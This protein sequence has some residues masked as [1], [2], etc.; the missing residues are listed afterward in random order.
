M[1]RRLRVPAA[2]ALLTFALLLFCKS[3]ARAQD[4]VGGAGRTDLSGGAGSSGG[5]RSSTPR[6]PKARAASTVRTVTVTKVVKFTAT[7]GT[8]A[9]AAA[10]EAA[11][12]IE[13]VRG[14]EGKEGTVPKGE[15]VFIFNDLKPG[16]YRVAAELDGYQ[17]AEEEVT[18][19]ANKNLS[20]T[21]DL[22]PI[23]YSVT[24]AANVPAGEVRY[25]PV[26]AV[27]DASGEV[28]YNVAGETRVTP[29][30]GGRA[31]LPN[32][33]PGTYGVDVRSADVGYQTLLATFTL[34]GQTTYSVTL[35]KNLSTKTFSAAWASLDAWE[36]PA[37]W[38]VG[39][40]KLSVSGRGIALPKDESA[41]HY[42]DF[43]LFS[44][45]KML[46]GVAV[47]YVV[48]AQDAQNYYLIQITGAKADEPY[49]LRG[50]VV[51]NG[52]A[53]RFGSTI[54]VDAFTS[55]LKANQFFSVSMEATG[56][57]FKVSI[58]DSETG[59]VL[60]LGTLEDPNRNFP[61][62]AAGVAV[63]DNEQNEV[64]RFVVCTSESPDCP[65]G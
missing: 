49:V 32:L 63:R 19:T 17:P 14:G 8:L 59:D 48:R 5:T 34:P 24:I 64:E 10:S 58:T 41:R 23:T 2:L 56:N 16:R 26:A 44:N 12:L 51:K 11:I 18:V 21:L 39:S 61:I 29:L 55:T 36:A 33:R 62:G 65:R 35:Q 47:S 53:Q 1:L 28:K 15:G 37:G 38:R 3:E 27:K 42:A 40:R 54:P 60:P 22:K 30:Q 50:F 9:V 7:T 6:K 4:L 43:R 25:A 46:N 20:V 57:K 52:A 13:P 45:V 31:T